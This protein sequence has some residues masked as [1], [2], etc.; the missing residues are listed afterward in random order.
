[1]ASGKGWGSIDLLFPRFLL[2]KRGN[3]YKEQTDK[4]WEKLVDLLAQSTDANILPKVLEL[5]EHEPDSQVLLKA[6]NHLAWKLELEKQ[7]INLE[8]GEING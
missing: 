4:F 7:K 8:T 2:K 5:V 1:M 6:C 3:Y